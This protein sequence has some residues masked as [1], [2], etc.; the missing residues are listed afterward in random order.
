M[1]TA[2]AHARDVASMCAS[3]L[4]GAKANI[5]N[6]AFGT[7]TFMPLSGHFRIRILHCRD[8]AGDAGADDGIG[9]RRGLALMRTGLERYVERRALRRLLGAA[10][11]LHFGVR[12]P[13][14]LGP[15]ARDN[16]AVFHDDRP[17][18]RIWPGPSQI[19]PA[20]GKREPHEAL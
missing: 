7:Q 5:D 13:T 9:T 6:D 3:G 2:S 15:T 16:R 17:D 1:R 4:I 19:A 12:S 18:R 10:Q 11:G 8:H 14:R 20:K